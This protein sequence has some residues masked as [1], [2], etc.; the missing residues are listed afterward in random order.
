M[1]THID[2]PNEQSAVTSAGHL[3]PDGLPVP[4]RLSFAQAAARVRVVLC[5]T[6]H[7]G[8]IGS[9]A[10]ALKTMGF[11]RL[12]LVRPRYF[13]DPEAIALSS[14]ANDVLDGA[15][16]V[17]SLSEAL[18]GT[19]MAVA[20]TARRRELAVAPLW[21]RQAVEKL[22]D[23]LQVTPDGDVALVFG[24]ETSGLSNEELS[25]CQHWTMIPANPEYSS[26][27]LAAA[28]QLMSYEL[29]L[30]LL[31]PGVPP[32]IADA[33]LPAAHEAIEGLLRHTERVAIDSGFLDPASPKRFLH[34]LRRLTARAAME[35]E[36]VAILRGLLAAVQ[37]FIK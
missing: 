32:A 17:E 8:N 34:R 31:D 36:E 28:V 5:Q 14:G 37:K 20:V 23:V 11:A 26:L 7:P 10:R 6:S 29:R 4:P 35:R 21:A 24:N 9:A 33:G 27:N 16:V 18:F 12:V 15:Q 22:S 13:P 1:E 3:R 25:L 30:A 19:V 2:S